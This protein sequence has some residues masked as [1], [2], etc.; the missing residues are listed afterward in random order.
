MKRKR[1]HDRIV[2][3]GYV[4]YADKTRNPN[5]PRPESPELAAWRKEERDKAEAPLII[6]WTMP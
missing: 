3:D 6:E 4:R 1:H 5:R 2:I